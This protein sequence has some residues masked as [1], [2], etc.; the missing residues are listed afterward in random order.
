MS[1]RENR[2]RALITGASSGL[3][4]ALAFRCARSGWDLL[5]VARRETE[6]RE[7][8]GAISA[9][10]GLAAVDVA[11]IALDLCLPDAIPQLES[12]LAAIGIRPEEFTLLINNAGTGDHGPFLESEPARLDRAIALNIQV[13][14]RLTR[15]LAPDMRPGGTICMIAS[16]AAF[17]PGPLMAT[18]YATK[19]YLLSLGEALHEELRPRGLRVTVAC[20]GP[21]RSAFHAA[22]GINST[23]RL[24]S[25]D[26]IA[27]GVLAAIRRGRV[28]APLGAGPWLWSLIG[29]RLPRF[30]ARRL[31]HRVQL[32]RR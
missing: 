23:E 24:P 3:G 7:L 17:T 2:G 21:F 18:Y 12:G 6:L 27:A 9:E 22:A 32:R 19:S 29:P 16:V 8:A 30:L 10:E 26:S 14:T 5:L 13:P 11:V 15:R 25:A 31:V 28:V 4:R 20:P 1:L